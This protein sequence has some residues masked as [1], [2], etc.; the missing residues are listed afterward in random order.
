MTD[1]E[2]ELIADLFPEPAATGRPS[3]EL[4]ELLD[5]IFWIVR[6]PVLRGVVFLKN[7]VLGKRC[8]TTLTGGMP[9]E[10]LTKCANDCCHDLSLK[11]KPIR[12]SGSSTVR[13]YALPDVPQAAEKSDPKEPEDH[14]LGRSRCGFSTKIHLACDAN[15]LPLHFEITP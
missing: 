9:T 13:S 15:G 10:H 6:D 2:W 3:R 5:A 12:N 7:S 4:R 8:T 1:A 14:A 11:I